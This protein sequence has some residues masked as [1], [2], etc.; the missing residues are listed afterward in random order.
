MRSYLLAPDRRARSAIRGLG[1]YTLLVF[2]TAVAV[3]ACGDDYDDDYPT[4]STGPVPSVVSGAGAIAPKVAEFQTLLG[5][6]A[7]GSTV[8]QQASGHR[9][10]N[11]DGV[12]AT[13]TNTNNFSGAFFNT[14]V[15]RGLIT[16]S[17]GS[18]FRVSD[19]DFG[20]VNGS[21]SVG[22]NPFSGA[23]TF[24]PV[25]SNVMDVTF[26]VAGAPTP[27]TVTG[28]AA[29]FSDV[30]IFGATK[31]ELFD[32]DNRSLGVHLVPARS[33]AAG[34]SFLGVKFDAPIVARVRITLGHA[35]VSAT[36]KDINDGGTTD[37][38]ITDDFFYGEPRA[39][40]S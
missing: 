30:D 28:F 19:N 39:I 36:A 26:Q 14:N 18:G 6:A 15:T 34:F 27:A 11:W 4:G 38:V 17:P 2:G 7:N 40:G 31:M 22:F 5:G 21:D 10:V 32:K 16:T 24:A 37:L 25:G 33:D 29:V 1:V 23:R 13:A 12:P 8:G 3:G 20:D 9:Q 35:A